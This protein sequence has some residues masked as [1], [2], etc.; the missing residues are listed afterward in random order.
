M[1]RPAPSRA[2]LPA[3][4]QPPRRISIAP[5]VAPSPAGASSSS[6]SPHSFVIVAPCRGI[7]AVPRRVIMVVLRTKHRCSLRVVVQPHDGALLRTRYA[8]ASLSL[9]PRLVSIVIPSMLCM[10]HAAALS[11]RPAS[12][13]APRA[14]L[15]LLA[16]R[17]HA[18]P[19]A[20][21]FR[22]GWL[23]E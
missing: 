14:S 5:A 17:G 11:C 1:T 22:H 15:L 18:C 21:G 13:L 2:H 16:C 19:C 3:Q 4:L 8:G 12:L 7:L 20:L 10:C 6:R 23:S 9:H